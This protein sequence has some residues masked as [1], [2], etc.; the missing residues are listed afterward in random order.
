MAEFEALEGMRIKLTQE[1]VVSDLFGAGYGLGNYGQFAVSTQVHFQPTELYTIEQLMARPSVL[2]QKKKDYLLIDD[3]SA[4]AFPDFIPF[5][6]AQGFSETNPLRVGDTVKAI[7]GVL[8][9]YDEHYVVIPDLSQNTKSLEIDSKSRPKAPLIDDR[10]NLVITSFNLENYFNGRGKNSNAGFPTRRGANTYSG[11]ELQSQKIVAALTKLDA[12]IISLMELEND[13]YGPRSAIAELTRRLNKSLAK[14]KAYAYIDPQL[15]R[16]GKDEISVGILYRKAKLLPQGASRVINFPHS[17][18]SNNSQLAVNKRPSLAQ[19][20]LIADKPLLVVSSH[21]KSKG[22]PCPSDNLRLTGIAKAKQTLQGHC[23]QERLV[24]TKFLSQ[25]L[26]DNYRES[27]PTLLL[28]DFNSYSQEEPL[29]FLYQ[30]G[31]QNLKARNQF[32]YSYQGYLGNLDHALANKALLP[33]VVSS[34]SWNINSVEDVLLNYQTED[35]GQ[36]YPSIDHYGQ[37]D[38]YRSSDHDPIVIAIK[39]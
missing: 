8:H 15:P 34:Q 26:K 19:L 5:P 30:A 12:D 14:K 13:G 31:F 18:L 39:L 3:G 21:L 23:N 7:E 37:G 2:E 36:N 38:E 28:G 6:N 10:A 33:S 24:A 11:F 20:F 17:S 16:L 27:M 1:L 32:S 35:N 29:Q 22:R 4:K 25:Y 9:A